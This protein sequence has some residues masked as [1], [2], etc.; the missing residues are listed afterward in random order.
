MSKNKRILFVT[1]ESVVHPVQGEIINSGDFVYFTAG[2]SFFFNQNVRYL[3][4]H[5]VR[6]KLYKDPCYVKNNFDFVITMHSDLFRESY[7]DWLCDVTEL[8]SRFSVPIYVLGICL[9]T[10]DVNYEVNFSDKLNN[11]VKKFV[12]LILNSG[13]DLT[14]RGKFTQYYLENLGFNNLFVSGC[15]SLFIRGENAVIS[16]KRCEKEEF[17]PCFNANAAQNIPERF[18]EEYPNAK[19]VDQDYYL[20]FM[21]EPWTLTE[22]RLRKIRPIVRKLYLH[23]RLIGDKNYAMWVRKVQ[24]EGFNFFYGRKLHGN[25]VGLQYNTPCFIVPI[26]TRV[27][28]VCDFFS[29]PNTFHTS[30]NEEK[31]DLFEL[32]KSLDFSEFNTRYKDSYHAFKNYLDQHDIPNNMGNSSDY[33][34]Y[35]NSFEYYDYE[36][37]I[38]VISAKDNVFNLIKKINSEK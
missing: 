8:Y 27:R 36:K 37:D 17:N 24:K 26:D 18:Y 21:Y 20:D 29:I 22:D 28:E 32:Y 6:I 19:Y 10:L 3:S 14:L 9:N 7:Y 15:P 16:S 30:F 23:S 38:K 31:D 33:L 11:A 1:Q 5:E 4:E 34:S 35:I 12:D 13:G 2:A 25:I